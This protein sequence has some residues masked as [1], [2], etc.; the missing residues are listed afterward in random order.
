MFATKTKKW[1]MV[2]KK[3]G[4]YHDTSR[5]GNHWW[6]SYHGHPFYTKKV[7]YGLDFWKFSKNE[8]F[9][10]D[11]FIIVVLKNRKKHNNIMVV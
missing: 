9:L 6:A 5:R 8:I 4:D 7:I 10:F 2:I 1:G 3:N 11:K